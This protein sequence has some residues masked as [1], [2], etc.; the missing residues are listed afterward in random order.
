VRFYWLTLGVLSVWRLTHLLQAEDG[1]W[2]LIV[3]LRR[4]AG[5]GFWGELL[6]CFYC[7]S[8]WIA[9]PFAWFLGERAKERL[10]LWLALSG[11]A[12]LLERITH[13]DA[14][15][16]APYWKEEDWKEEDPDGMLRTESPGAAP[17]RAARR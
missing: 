12:I 15:A 1:P 14:K 11:G 8:L 16:P 17:D 4:L 10:F 13:P 2:N 3:R 5:T 7:L 6:D 9:A